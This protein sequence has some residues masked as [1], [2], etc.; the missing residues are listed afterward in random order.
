MRQHIL[1]TVD[2][3]SR[4]PVK[5]CQNGDADVSEQAQHGNRQ[6]LGA[7]SHIHLARSTLVPQ[8]VIGC[9]REAPL[10]QATVAL[11]MP[12]SAERATKPLGV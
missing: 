6:H 11:H 12:S 3:S 10:Q 9:S 2:Q 1:F 8:L 7:V 5:T 4:P